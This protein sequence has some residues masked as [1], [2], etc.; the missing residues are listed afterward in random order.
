M[1]EIYIM[2]TQIM[3]AISYIRNVSKPKV[4]TDKIVTYLKNAG[5]LNWDK[6]S[7]KAN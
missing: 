3:E 2:D 5:V 4:T 6:E 1:F 7:I